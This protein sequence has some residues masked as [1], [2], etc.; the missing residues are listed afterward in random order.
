MTLSLR[1]IP[2]SSEDH[3]NFV[4]WQVAPE[5]KY[6]SGAPSG[7]KRQ[8]QDEIIEDFLEG[9]ANTRF[10]LKTPTKLHE[11]RNSHGTPVKILQFLV[12]EK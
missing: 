11:T 2:F 9:E 7:E 4:N 3:H 6:L 1:K 10:V 12:F 8:A 5:K